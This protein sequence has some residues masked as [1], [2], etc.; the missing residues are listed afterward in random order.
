MVACRADFSLPISPRASSRTS[1][2]RFVSFVALFSDILNVPKLGSGGH[3]THSKACT[4]KLRNPAS[5]LGSPVT[6][7]AIGIQYCH[8]CQVVAASTLRPRV[9]VASADPVLHHAKL[10]HFRQYRL[11]LVC[12]MRRHATQGDHSPTVSIDSPDERMTLHPAGQSSWPALFLGI[13]AGFFLDL[14]LQSRYI[15][16]LCVLW[17]TIRYAPCRVSA[18]GDLGGVCASFRA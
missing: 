7:A 11:N 13:F 5:A 17:T 2:T 12:K 10:K 8:K 18:K 6:A 3:I 1:P 14:S 15:T 4:V 9:E 16:V